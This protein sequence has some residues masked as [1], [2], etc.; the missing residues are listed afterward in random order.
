MSAASASKRFFCCF[1]FLANLEPH[2]VGSFPTPD[3]VVTLTFSPHPP[4]FVS[5]FLNIKISKNNSDSD[6]CD[7]SGSNIPVTLVSTQARFMLTRV[8]GYFMDSEGSRRL[9]QIR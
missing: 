3:F 6:F 1:I 2:F 8:N 5:S 9:C 4:S 7:Y